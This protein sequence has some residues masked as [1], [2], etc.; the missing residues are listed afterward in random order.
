MIRSARAARRHGGRLVY[1]SHELY[2]DI[3]G[4]SDQ[5][6]RRWRK[7]ERRA[8]V[9]ADGIITVSES[10]ADELVRRY[11]VARPTVLLNVPAP[12]GTLSPTR[13]PLAELKR[14]REMMVLYSGGVSANRG[15][16]QLAEAA[17]TGHGWHLV[18]MGWGP[19][20]G[21][22]RE[23]LP[24]VA[25]VEP[26]AADQ[27]VGAAS[28]ADVGVI[29][30]LPTSLNNALSL[31][32]KLFE[33]IQAGLAIA[34]SD[35]VEIA[36][37]IQNNHVGIVFPP[38]DVAAIRDS[39]DSLAADGRRLAEMRSAAN[40]AARAFNWDREKRKLIDLYGGFEP[41]GPGKGRP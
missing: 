40:E 33:Y 16:E 9:R 8:I 25:V 24:S 32:N 28:A 17:R 27:V 3:S 41:A 5:E 26:V 38:G 13:S 36:R 6:R 7:Q 15:L 12:A 21:R 2:P 34:S 23:M 19:L 20:L 4:L 1:D 18:I 30:Y 22:I 31:P 11:G 29:P 37:F 14:P 10:L 35:L 39:L